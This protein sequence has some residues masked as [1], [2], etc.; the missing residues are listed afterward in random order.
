LGE[1]TKEFKERRVCQGGC[2]GSCV[3]AEDRRGDGK[4]VVEL[5]SKARRGVFG[6]RLP[7]LNPGNRKDDSLLGKNYL[8]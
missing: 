5:T 4:V 6:D 3:E 8:Q 1:I 2:R 7:A